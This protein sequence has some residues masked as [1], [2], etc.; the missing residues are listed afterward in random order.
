MPGMTGTELASIV[1]AHPP[2]TP[3]LIV[4]GYSEARASCFRRPIKASR[5]QAPGPAKMR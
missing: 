1:R 4:S 3:V 5:L 2:G